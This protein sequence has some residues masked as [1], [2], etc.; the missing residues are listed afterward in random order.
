MIERIDEL[1]TIEEKATITIQNAL[2]KIEEQQNR[3]LQIDTAGYIELSN[4]FLQILQKKHE[5]H[6]RNYDELFKSVAK[7]TK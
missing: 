1:G 7:K 6:L 3:K 2:L 4:K 5:L